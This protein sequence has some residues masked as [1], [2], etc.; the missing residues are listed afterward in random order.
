VICLIFAFAHTQQFPNS[1]LSNFPSM[2]CFVLLVEDIFLVA[3]ISTYFFFL[4]LLKNIL[5]CF[6][7]HFWD[8]FPSPLVVG[9]QFSFI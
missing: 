8:S 4:W 2:F 1:S 3:S 7:D 9:S 6:L 5:L